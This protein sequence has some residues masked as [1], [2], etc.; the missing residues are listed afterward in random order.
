MKTKKIFGL[1]AFAAATFASGV[2]LK[3]AVV[4][5]AQPFP[6]SQVRLLDSPF[7][8][9]ML[10]DQNYLLSLECDRLLRNFR[11]NAE[12]ADGEALRRLGS[13]EIANCAGTASGIICPRAR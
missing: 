10:R 3:A 12:C 11:V 8:D 4:P 2:G 7:R 1:L 13:A 6:L 9:A 5:Q